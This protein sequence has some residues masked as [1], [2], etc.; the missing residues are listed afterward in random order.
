MVSSEWCVGTGRDCLPEG[1]TIFESLRDAARSRSLAKLGMTA[2]LAAAFLAA[3]TY[4]SAVRI[5]EGADI[6]TV[7]TVPLRQT[8]AIRDTEIRWHRWFGPW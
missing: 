4:G 8:V 6:G 7:E 5:D 2:L 1:Q 3:A